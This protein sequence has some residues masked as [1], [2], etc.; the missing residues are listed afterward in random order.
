MP[1]RNNAC[2]HEQRK[3][4]AR[5]FAEDNIQAGFRWLPQEGSSSGC[6]PRAGFYQTIDK[7]MEIIGIATRAGS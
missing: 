6:S 4:S 5:D 2:D 1:V 3:C 7:F